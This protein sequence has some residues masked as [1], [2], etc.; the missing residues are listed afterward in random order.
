MLQQTNNQLEFTTKRTI[1]E[2]EQVL[3]NFLVLNNFSR[4]FSHLCVHHT[5]KVSS[6]LKFQSA[7]AESLMG[8]VRKV[9]EENQKLRFFSSRV[10]A[11][12]CGHLCRT[13]R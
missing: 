9:T 12:S 6:E 1:M 11:W 10:A 7:R 3:N 5:D 2:N 13:V 4:T 8:T